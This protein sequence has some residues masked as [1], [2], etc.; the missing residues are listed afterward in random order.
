VVAHD[1]LAGAFAAHTVARNA[2]FPQQRAAAMSIED[3]L[4]NDVIVRVDQVRGARM[5]RS[6]SG[7]VALDDLQ[8]KL[9]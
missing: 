3:D 2:G 8:A 5:K 4:R 9:R 7:A 6:S 1:R